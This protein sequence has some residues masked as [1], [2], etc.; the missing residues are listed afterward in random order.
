MNDLVTLLSVP[1]IY[2][3][4]LIL[5]CWNITLLIAARVLS[6]CMTNGFADLFHSLL[7]GC[8]P[9]AVNLSK[10]IYSILNILSI[11]LSVIWCI[12]FSSSFLVNIFF[13][14]LI[15][16]LYPDWCFELWSEMLIIIASSIKLAWIHG[17]QLQSLIQTKML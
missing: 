10:D 4:I 5:N 7:T 13:F 9:V 2:L 6:I 17:Y 14:F 12:F 1:I 11:V 16:N 15:T 8:F 3:F